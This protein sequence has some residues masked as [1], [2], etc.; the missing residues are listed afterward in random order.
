MEN[1]FFL[2]TLDGNQ[3]NIVDKIQGKAMNET[4]AK[5]LY[6]RAFNKG[7][8]GLYGKIGD[9]QKKSNEVKRLFNKGIK[10]VAPKSEFDAKKTANDIMAKF[11]V[12]L[13]A[14]MITHAEFKTETPFT[15][16]DK[17]LAYCE[18]AN[19]DPESTTVRGGFRVIEV[20]FGDSKRYTYL[21]KKQYKKLGEVVINNRK[22]KVI[23]Y[24][25]L[26][27]KKLYEIADKN[28]KSVTDFFK[29]I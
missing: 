10:R 2:Y 24:N 27:P 25:I 15:D 1:F 26:T 22:A 5:D 6:W 29:V 13:I 23:S 19:N 28:H 20:V 7:I 21:V 3:M 9:E 12:K 16:Y 4:Q 8:A 18:S 17:Y 11:N 14:E